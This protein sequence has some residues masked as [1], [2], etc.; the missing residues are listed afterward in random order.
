VHHLH[1]AYSCRRTLACDVVIVGPLCP[2]HSDY[3]LHSS[4]ACLCTSL[5]D[6]QCEWEEPGKVNSSP[7]LSAVWLG[8]VQL[9]TQRQLCCGCVITRCLRLAGGSCVCAIVA[10]GICRCGNEALISFYVCV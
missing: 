1:S 4:C 10:C 3:R 9:A 2:L 8:S 7:K 6:I 5:C